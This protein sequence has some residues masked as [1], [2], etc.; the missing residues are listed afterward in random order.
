MSERHENAPPYLL[1]EGARDDDVYVHGYT[2]AK[3]KEHYV[4]VGNHVER[5]L[6]GS[7]LLLICL[8]PLFPG[9]KPVEFRLH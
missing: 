4:T 2:V 5:H 3:R 9:L 1:A 6:Y 8:G 7:T